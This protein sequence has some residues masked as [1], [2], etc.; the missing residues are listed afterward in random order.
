MPTAHPPQE[1]TFLAPLLA[2]AVDV[3]LQLDADLPLVRLVPDIRMLQE[4]LGGGPL[5]VVL[6]QAA[7]DEAEEL[8][9]PGGGREGQ[10]GRVWKNIRRKKEKR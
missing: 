8:L 3:V 1:L 5:G 4:L 10:R 9:G 6:H 2:R 7:L